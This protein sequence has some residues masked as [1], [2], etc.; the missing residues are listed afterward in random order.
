MFYYSDVIKYS[1]VDK[2]GKL[3]LYGILELFQ[4]C[5][6]IHSVDIK[7]DF[8]SMREY[9]K[10]WVLLSWRIKLYKEIKLYDKVSIGTWA[11]GNDKLYGYRN[12]IIKD[13]NGETLACADTK[14][15][16]IDMETRKPCRISE[17][18]ME[19]YAVGERLDIGK[20]PRKLK[21]SDDITVLE[22]VRV[23]KSYI[24]TNY[25]MNN[26]AYFRLATE[27]LPDDFEYDTVDAVYIKE[28]TEGMKMIPVV[29][30]EEDGIGISLEAEDGTVFTEI[31][32][33]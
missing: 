19:G 3:P 16:L 25:H 32:F 9:G 5:I 28:A 26:T 27:Y 11:C 15:L 18:D 2:E 24:D 1:N 17:A 7:K 33:Y 29:H 6:N 13:E 4:N 20:C 22:P 10:A 14:W 30:R 8:E 23:L 31:K 12:Y 21:L